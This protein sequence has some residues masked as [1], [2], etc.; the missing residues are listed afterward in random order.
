MQEV[1][2]A[3]LV[4]ILNGPIRITQL[5]QN[6]QSPTTVIGGIF[7]LEE[8]KNHGNV[9]RIGGDDGAQ[10]PEQTN[11]MRQTWGRPY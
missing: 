3:R 11:K 6:F 7:T 9:A 8:T 5:Q 1:V 4:I 2:D 10:E